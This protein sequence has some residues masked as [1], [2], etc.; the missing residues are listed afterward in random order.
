MSKRK[1]IKYTT[2]ER[3]EFEPVKRWTG[4][5]TT[6]VRVEGLWSRLFDDYCRKARN[7]DDEVESAKPHWIDYCK[8][9]DCDLDAVA[10]DD[11]LHQFIPRAGLIGIDPQTR[12]LVYDN[13]D[14]FTI[15]AMHNV[16]DTFWLFNDIT[17]VCA[18]PFTFEVDYEPDIAA[19]LRVEPVWKVR[20]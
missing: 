14:T 8:E 15:G 9:F 19:S 2:A 4:D 10:A 12:R 17:P 5:W 6:D 3:V 16:S 20:S 13:D 18:H 7:W 11:A 1:V